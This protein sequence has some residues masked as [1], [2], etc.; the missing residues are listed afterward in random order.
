MV[1]AKEAN[2]S[3]NRNAI[4]PL[5]EICDDEESRC[6]PEDQNCRDELVS[7]FLLYSE[8]DEQ[9][10]TNTN[11]TNKNILPHTFSPINFDNNE[12]DYLKGL[13]SPDSDNIPAFTGLISKTTNLDGS[14]NL[15][16]TQTF[17]SV[18]LTTFDRCESNSSQR[19]NTNER[20]KNINTELPHPLSASFKSNVVSPFSRHSSISSKPIVRKSILRESTTSNSTSMNGKI[21]NEPKA[22]Q[23][24]LHRSL[25][26]RESTL[27]RNSI[28]KKNMPMNSPKPIVKRLQPTFPPSAI[29]SSVN[30]SVGK[31]SD[32]FEEEDDNEFVVVQ[33]DTPS[34]N[35]NRKQSVTNSI[36]NSHHSLTITSDNLIKLVSY[37]LKTV[38]ELIDRHPNELN[39]KNIDSDL[40]L[41]R[42]VDI[43]NVSELLEKNQT[44]EICKCF[45]FEKMLLLEYDNGK[46]QKIKIT[47]ESVNVEAVDS[48]IFRVSCLSAADINIFIFKLT[49]QDFQKLEKWVSALLNF[50]LEFHEETLSSLP[51]SKKNNT[52]NN[53][54]IDNV[55]NNDGKK[56][57]DSI[58]MIVKRGDLQISNLMPIKN[59]LKPKDLIVVLQIDSQKLI[60]KSENHNLINSI[61]ALKNYYELKKGIFRIVVLDE[62]L[63]ILSIGTANDILCQLNGLISFTQIRGKKLNG[64]LWSSLVMQKYYSETENDIG[65]VVLSNSEMKENT[66]CLF[67]DFFGS[68]EN[69]LKVHIGYLN[70]DYSDFITDL[71]E[72][73]TWMDLMEIICY[74]FDIEF[75]QDDCDDE[76]EEEAADRK[77]VSSYKTPQNSGD[78]NLISNNDR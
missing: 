3:K 15:N 50:D 46:F 64:N 35:R 72:I 66:N 28:S 10:E 25:I 34:V 71:V 19:I 1:V 70:V 68:Q 54:L 2:E 38:Q 67:K 17:P 45:L 48:D 13:P 9:I 16:N 56:I 43:F 27:S 24:I 58:D 36:L 60:K 78:S 51:E 55:D 69:L 12:I 59:N 44:Y 14:P 18:S 57:V 77:S 63:K 4:F 5:C 20:N 11:F 62:T 40:G 74:S 21:L 76:E 23:S 39:K 33:I 32:F 53:V 6:I 42:I 65:I 41:L 61:K 7:K 52:N 22:R 26:S 47:N 31:L 30:S 73:N 75:G 49:N 8:D 37:R 29:L